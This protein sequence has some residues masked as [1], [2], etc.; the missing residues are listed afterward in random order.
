MEKEEET[1]ELIQELNQSFK[2]MDNIYYELG[3]Y[4]EAGRVPGIVPPGKEGS[5]DCRARH[6]RGCLFLSECC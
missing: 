2:K 5:H 6:K 4:A 3:A 1:E